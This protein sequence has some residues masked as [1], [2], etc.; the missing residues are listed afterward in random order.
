[1]FLSAPPQ[2]SRDDERDKKSSILE[3]EPEEV[4]F[5]L[6]PTE[7]QS[8][9]AAKARRASACRPP[10]LRRGNDK[11]SREKERPLA[12]TLTKDDGQTR[13]RQHTNAE[14]VCMHQHQRAGYEA[15]RDHAP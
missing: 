13:A 3:P 14:T 7:L 6:I 10:H 5:A 9:K 15:R 1:M 8:Q 4:L 12:P 2:D 11:R